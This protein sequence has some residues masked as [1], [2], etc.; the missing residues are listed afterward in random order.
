MHR[1]SM[2]A[3]RIAPL[4][5]L[6]LALVLTACGTQ[7]AAAP[8]DVDEAIPAGSAAGAPCRATGGG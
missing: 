6:V 4:V 1:T 2:I 8:G 7:G 5:C 3:A